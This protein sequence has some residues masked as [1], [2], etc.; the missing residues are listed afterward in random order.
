MSIILSQRKT[1]LTLDSALQHD[2]D[3]T[4]N[5]VKLD[6]YKELCSFIKTTK[7]VSV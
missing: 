4:S 5:K 6:K 7:N 2:I 1:I 3:L